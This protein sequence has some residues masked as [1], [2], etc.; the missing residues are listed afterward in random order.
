MW[1][2]VSA[3]GISPEFSID[4]W[5]A[6]AAKLPGCSTS[7]WLI[8]CGLPLV[9]D[10]KIVLAKISNGVALGVADHCAHNHQLYVYLECGGFIARGEFGRALFGLGLGTGVAGRSL[11]NADLRNSDLS[12]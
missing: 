6:F 11:L 4:S 8:T 5:R 10:L 1:E 2:E 9:E 3:E 7:N 12:E